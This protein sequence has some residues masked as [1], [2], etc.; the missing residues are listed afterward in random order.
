MS[1]GLIKHLKRKTEEDSNTRILMSQWEFD[2][3][4]VGKS[5]E[6][7]GSYYPHFSSHNESHS[8]QILV[9]IERLLG[10][11]IEKLTATDT[12]LILEAA[13][14]HDIGMLF[15]ADEVQDVIEN[16]HFKDY[17]EELANNNVQDLHE[18]AKVWHKEGWEAALVHYDNPYKGVEKY[19]QMVAEWYRRDHPANSERVVLKPFEKLNISS[20][21]TELLPNRIYRYLA[22]ICLSHGKSFNYVMQ[23]LPFRQ[24]GMGTEDCHPRFVACL[25]RLGDLFDIDDNRFC[26]VMARQVGNMPSFSETHKHKH[27]AIREFQL[28]NETVSVTAICSTEMAY[29]ECRNWFDW[30]KEEIQNQMSQWKNIVPSRDF[31]LLPTINKLDVEMTDKKILLN[32]KP[33]KFSLDERSAI[34]LLQ[35]N[36]LYKD[37]MSIYRE[38]IQNAIDATMIR[39]WLE[40]GIEKS[41]EPLPPKANPYDEST[42]KIFEKYPIELDCRKVDDNEASTLWEFSIEDNGVGISRKDLEYMQKIAGS[43]N[44]KEKQKI[45]RQMPEWMRPSGEF[46]IGLHSAF[47]LMKDLPTEQQKI[48]I[49]TKSRM[50]HESFKIELNSPLSGKS[51]YCFIEEVDNLKK[52]GTKL[53]IQEVIS[54]EIKLDTYNNEI[55]LKKIIGNL[56]HSKPVSYLALYRLLEISNTI[57]N[58]IISFN[59]S[60]RLSILNLEKYSFLS[61]QIKTDGFYWD[62]KNNLGLKIIF[63]DAIGFMN[64]DSSYSNKLISKSELNL[65]Y[66][67]QCIEHKQLDIYDL[68]LFNDI[69]KLNNFGLVVDIYSSKSS[70]FLNL[71]RDE[72]KNENVIISYIEKSIQSFFNS[73]DNI[74]LLLRMLDFDEVKKSTL[75][76]LIGSKYR[77][78]DLWKSFKPHLNYSF[79]E[80]LDSDAFTLDFANEKFWD[81]AVQMC[82]NVYINTLEG[83][84]LEKLL[85]NKFLRDIFISKG[86]QPYLFDFGDNESS[87]LDFFSYSDIVFSKKDMSNKFFNK[88][89]WNDLNPSNYKYTT[90][91]DFIFDSYK[92]TDESIFSDEF[93]GSL[94]HSISNID[95]RIL[96]NSTVSNLLAQYRGNTEN[97]FIL[98][99]YVFYEDIILELK[100]ETLYKIYEPFINIS[101][102]SFEN[103]WDDIKEQ[104]IEISK[105]DHPD[106]YEAYLRGKDFKKIALNPLDK[107]YKPTS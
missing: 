71:N 63:Q 43:K 106:W 22:Q 50:T 44:N 73:E 16:E 89:N 70:Y 105:K 74:E 84:L 51:G 34:E 85:D 35:G 79:T 39:V 47:L 36:N 3:K 96:N 78:S 49:F 21:R 23:D 13:Y 4:L 91:E 14:W 92:W 86:F 82:T 2:E 33:M 27:Q 19:R 6:N 60:E 102:N 62:D 26:P 38:L 54:S 99:P 67:G 61:N 7:V 30:I 25:L 8:Q 56:S 75:L 18:F 1:A 69:N 40:H 103:L 88:V 55:D 77:E 15:N 46:G 28:D 29:I 9:N 42:R 12:W 107:V 32:N 66:R 68:N 95:L 72:L 100:N 5:L 94:F 11:N 87:S 53:V 80:I 57:T 52:Y 45:I 20:P 65:F 76:F 17:V 101:K 83:Y 59:L 58:P 37:D 81:E 64:R 24:T 41:Q 97:N 10:S 31:G 90:L 98:T 48:T 93:N 104:I